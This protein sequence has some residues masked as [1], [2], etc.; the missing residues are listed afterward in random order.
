M[1]DDCA[2][3]AVNQQ[4]TGLRCQWQWDTPTTDPG[5]VVG[6]IPV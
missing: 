6:V 3:S 2:M 5:S 4:G 1:P